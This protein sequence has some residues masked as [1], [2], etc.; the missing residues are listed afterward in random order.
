M[1]EPHALVKIVIEISPHDG[2]AIA[3]CS[4][5][6]RFEDA[7]N[8]A[9]LLWQTPGWSGEA[10]VWDFR[11]AAFDLSSPDVHDVA[12][13]VARNQRPMPPSRVALVAS[14]DVNFGLARMFEALRQDPR[15]AVRVFRDYD[16]AVAW[17]GS[18]GPDER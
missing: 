5:V 6:F 10:V 16:E 15:T 18:S 14:I 3:R 11:E 1:Q 7:R 13:F 9:V 2:M 4:G 12:Q 17:A 8:G